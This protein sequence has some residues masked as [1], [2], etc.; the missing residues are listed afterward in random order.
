MAITWGSVGEGKPT[1]E[2]KVKVTGQGTHPNNFPIVIEALNSVS[3]V[4][5]YIAG[6]SPASLPNNGNS[7][8]V[9]T[10]SV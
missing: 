9:G 10:L 2:Y 1:G 7:K 4:P 5:Q 8:G 6:G 3:F